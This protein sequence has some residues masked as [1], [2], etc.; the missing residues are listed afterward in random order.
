MDG[1]HDQKGGV[2]MARSFRFLAGPCSIEMKTPACL[3]LA[4]AHRNT[5]RLRNSIC[6]DLTVGRSLVKK[7]GSH[8]DV[9]CLNGIIVISH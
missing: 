6:D 1:C 9:L 4:N 2:V 3:Y 7:I 8:A 5:L